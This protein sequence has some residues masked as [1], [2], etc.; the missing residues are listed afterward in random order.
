MVK[1]LELNRYEVGILVN[2]LV[3]LRNK[4]IKESTITEPVDELLL[5]TMDCNAHMK[6]TYKKLEER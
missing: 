3:E 5:K 4:L 2:A 1:I 6:P